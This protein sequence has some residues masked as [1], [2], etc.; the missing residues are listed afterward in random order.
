MQSHAR[1]VTIIAGVEKGQ[2]MSNRHCIL[3][4]ALLVLLLSCPVGY[5]A[6]AGAR[7]APT[8]TDVAYDTT[9]KAQILDVYIGKSETPLPVMVFIHGGAW[10]AGSK[11]NVP[12]YLL[13]AVEK[14]QLSVVSVEYRFTNVALHPAQVNDCL[15]AIQ[16]VRHKAK[17]WKVDATRMAVSGGSA[18]GHLSL[19][20]ALVDDAADPK[21]ED[22]ISRQST[23]VSCAIGWAGPTDWGLLGKMPHT[24]PAWRRFIGYKPG[25]PA[26]EMDAGKKSSASPITYASADDPPVLL[27]HGTADAVVPVQHAEV[28]H[29]RLRKVKSKT[30][31]FKIEGAGHNVCNATNPKAVKRAMA[32]LNEHLKLVD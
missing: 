26:G 15:R 22:P 5:V 20:V 24:H 9:D 1:A 10:Q 14:G 7:A 6:D 31:L 30:E 32:F 17:T 18:G 2:E 25:T 3:S 11:K 21:A 27:V 28:L 13:Q 19:Y 29:A 8:L 12:R 23:R 16:F 4:V